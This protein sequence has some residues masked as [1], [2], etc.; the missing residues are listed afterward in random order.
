MQFDR[1]AFLA[2]LGTAATI[3]AMPCNQPSRLEKECKK[4][5]EKAA[6]RGLFASSMA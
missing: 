3:N 1:R 6:T 2:T 4:G 5:R